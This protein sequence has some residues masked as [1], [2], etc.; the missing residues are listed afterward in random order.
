MTEE[1]A[2]QIIKGLGDVEKE[3]AGLKVVVAGFPERVDHKILQHTVDCQKERTKVVANSV[4]K[5]TPAN[6]SGVFSFFGSGGVKIP[7]SAPKWLIYLVFGAAMA[8]LGKL[9]EA[10]EI[11]KVSQ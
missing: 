2:G 1:Q 8:L 9:S 4:Q 5:N 10:I 11:F 7:R 3:L 6:N